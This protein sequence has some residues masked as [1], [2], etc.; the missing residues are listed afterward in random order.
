MGGRD[1]EHDFRGGADDA[2]GEHM[3]AEYPAARI[4]ERGVQVRA[5]GRQGARE[6]DDLDVAAPQAGTA[7]AR[8]AQARARQ[9]ADGG[10]YEGGGDAMLAHPRVERGAQILA[11]VQAK[12]Q[13]LDRRGGRAARCA[14]HPSSSIERG[15]L[16]LSRRDSARSARM[17]PPVWQRAQ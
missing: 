4:G 17:T 9:A 16:A 12:R 13:Q 10:E 15:K 3:A 14:F 2:A 6:R 5:V 1:A 8:M 7:P 11:R